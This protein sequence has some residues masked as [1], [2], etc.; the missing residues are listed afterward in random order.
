[1]STSSSVQ[2]AHLHLAQTCHEAAELDQGADSLQYAHVR[3][4][5][6]LVILQSWDLAGIQAVLTL[7]Y[8]IFVY[9]GIL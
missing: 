7:M 9:S 5:D 3:P 4:T 2:G 6:F 1:M 8:S